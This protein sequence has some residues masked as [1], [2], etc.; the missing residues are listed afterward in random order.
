MSQNETST[1][2]SAFAPRQMLVRLVARAT[3]RP[4]GRKLAGLAAVAVLLGVTVLQGPIGA[5]VDYVK[6]STSP[7]VTSQ[8]VPGAASD[9]TQ[10]VKPSAAQ[11][12][13]LAAKAKAKAAKAAKAKAL[14]AKAAALEASAR[15]KA[16]QAKAA[17]DAARAARAQALAAAKAAK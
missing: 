11:Q 17:Q 2:A 7:T 4:S 12:K 10:A 5:L 15:T 14:A 1:T 3:T 9:V 16:A 13:I 6:S 8:F